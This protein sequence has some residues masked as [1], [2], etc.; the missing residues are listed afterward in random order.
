MEG[1]LDLRMRP[2]LRRLVTRTLAIIPAALTIWLVGDSGNPY[3]LLILS[4]QVILSMQ[5]PFL[6]GDPS[7]SLHQRP[8]AHGP[9][10]QPA[11]GAR[12]RPGLALLC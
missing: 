3:G 8:F 6:R 10:R 11:V 9:I 2:W 7:H 4:D 1:F 12:A 5:L